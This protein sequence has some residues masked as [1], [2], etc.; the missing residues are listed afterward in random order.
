MKQGTGE[1]GPCLAV[2][3]EPALGP[4]MRGPDSVNNLDEL[5]RGPLA[6]G[7]KAAPADPG[8]EPVRPC[9]EP[10]QD[11][12]RLVTRGNCEIMDVCCFKPLRL[13]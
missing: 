11:V 5:G 2:S 8:G 1:R 13:Q 3:Q 9:A 10:S 4:S 7:G 6:A 12:P